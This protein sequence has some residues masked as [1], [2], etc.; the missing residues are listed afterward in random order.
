[1]NGGSNLWDR[2]LRAASDEVALFDARAVLAETVSRVLPE[3][4]FV[5]TRTAVLR[6]AG[7]R[8]GAR[9]R[10]MGVVRLTG[11]NRQ[12]ELLSIGSDCIIAGSLHVDLGAAVRIGDRVNI[13]HHVVLLT[14]SH[15]IGPADERCGGHRCLP[16]SIGDGAWIGSRVTILPGVTVGAGAVVSAGAVVTRDVMPNVLVG[17]VPA[18]VLE[19]FSAAASSEAALRG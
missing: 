13:G 9:S 18:K 16:I 3:Q 11:R 17:G 19:D 5:R 4:S 1:M 7:F 6:A 12:I 14:V 15:E 8:I 2:L 10:I